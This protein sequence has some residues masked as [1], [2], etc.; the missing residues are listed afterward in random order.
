MKF[1]NFLT[2][3]AGVKY[4]IIQG[5]F[6]WQGVG[7]ASIAAPVSEAGGLGILTTICYASP[8]EFK[9]DV[10]KAKDMTDKPFA[11]NFTVMKDT[12]WDNDFHKE[13]I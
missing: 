1:D 12:K 4:P 7:S 8:E 6:G 9:D 13:Y 2:Q 10:Q 3:K 11:V 5:A